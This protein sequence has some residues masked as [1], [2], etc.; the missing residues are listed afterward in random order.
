MAISLPP[1]LLS[2]IFLEFQEAHLWFEKTSVPPCRTVSQV[3][4]KWR[5]VALGSNRLWTC[6]PLESTQWVEACL[7]RSRTSCLE[8]NTDFG[9]AT[10]Y[11]LRQSLLLIYPELPRVDSLDFVLEI[12]S[13][14]NLELLTEVFAGLSLHPAPQLRD[15]NINLSESVGT[16]R[17]PHPVP[18]CLFASQKLVSLESASFCSCELSSSWSKTLLTA[19]LRSLSLDH[20]LAW[21]DVDEMVQFFKLIPNLRYF[22]LYVITPDTH[23]FN[24]STSSK[25][26]YRTVSLPELAI[27]DVST[28]YL[29]VTS[30]LAYMTIPA[31]ASLSIH[32]IEDDWDLRSGNEAEL[33]LTINLSTQ[34][35]R[36][37]FAPAIAAGHGYTHLT[38]NP[39]G[40][41]A[42]CEYGSC[43]LYNNAHLRDPRASIA[44]KL[45]PI[46]FDFGLP[47]D[48]PHLSRSAYAS[49]LEQPVL[50]T[51]TTIRI[52]GELPQEV[53]SCFE[54]WTTVETLELSK[55]LDEHG[56]LS[57]FVAAMLRQG[58]RLFPA[59]RD[60]RIFD[61][62]I[63][64]PDVSEHEPGVRV[65][66]EGFQ[67]IDAREFI[68]AIEKLAGYAHFERL[69]FS[70]CIVSVQALQDVKD[71]LG[72]RNVTENA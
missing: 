48:L 39:S 65:E 30:L 26:S 42:S 28:R 29:E 47:E 41:R 1:E 45:A 59:L 17:T 24:T 51:A 18:A 66:G 43:E 22:H 40:I 19:S 52:H 57:G 23:S 3:C 9:T 36:A 53:W 38:I 54:R 11:A 55:Y 25:Y 68:V 60:L 62:I 72:A 71:I 49:I 13:D 10:D 35:I 2:K 44:A 70:R 37:H 34:A 7:S 50:E 64:E 21:R 15:L 4:R 8:V 20:A 67:G 32:I 63:I 5:E 56:A 69:S 27:F 31:T 12:E 16:D 14:V 33:A 61:T 46:A 6:L 58:F